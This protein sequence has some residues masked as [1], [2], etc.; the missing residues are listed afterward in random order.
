[1]V[2]EQCVSVDVV[3]V[4][5]RGGRAAR[6]EFPDLRG[7][8]TKEVIQPLLDWVTI[9]ITDGLIEGDLM[10]D[11]SCE[12]SLKEALTAWLIQ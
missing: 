11:A 8:E 10:Q 12:S 4:A 9:S 7:I 1:M 2:G 5:C 6:G 3:E